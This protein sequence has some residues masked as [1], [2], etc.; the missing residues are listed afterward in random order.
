MNYK[1]TETLLLIIIISI[2]QHD[3]IPDSSFLKQPYQD[4]LLNKKLQLLIT[5]WYCYPT[6]KC[7]RT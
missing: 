7:N 6:V 1:D 4:E 5:L 2:N 3:L